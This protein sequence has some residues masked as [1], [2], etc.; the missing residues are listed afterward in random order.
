MT[1]THYPPEF[2]LR[3]AREAAEVGNASEVARRYEVHPTMVGRWL[4]AYR[5]DGE[6]A[7]DRPS[8][9]GKRSRLADASTHA[10]RSRELERENERLKQILGEKD[11]EIAILRGLVKKGS[12][13]LPKD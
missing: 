8:V 11:L 7:F 9:N 3:V 13:R 10:V 2:K 5:R 1:R 6:G 12:R 4:K